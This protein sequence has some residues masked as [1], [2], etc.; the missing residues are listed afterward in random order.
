MIN[1]EARKDDKAAV[2]TQLWESYKQ[3]PSVENKNNIVLHYISIVRVMVLRI[4]PTY[5]KRVEFDDLMSCGVLGLMDAIDR[6]DS[7]RGFQ[8]ET[9]AKKRIYGEMLDYMRKQDFISSSM[10]A[11]INKYKAATDKLQTELGREPTN[12]ELAQR[13]ELTVQQVEKVAQDDYL[14][15]IVR[16]ESVLAGYG[17]E[18]SQI[19][20]ESADTNPEDVVVQKEMSVLLAGAID[21]MPQNERRVLELYYEEELL[22]R[23]IAQILGVTE[24]R[25]SQIHK[26]ALLRLRETLNK[27]QAL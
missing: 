27:Q 15:S 19:R 24:S 3:D 14:C 8:F 9:F 1:D 12:E 7:T 18:S 16:F 5:H 23:E 10:R 17:D 6:F 11:R 22:L 20:D 26:K 13:L 2:A 4:M 21:T 25:V